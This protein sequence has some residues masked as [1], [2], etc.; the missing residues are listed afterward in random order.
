MN[1]KR[2]GKI[3]MVLQSIS[4]IPLLFFGFLIMAIAYHQCTKTI[5]AE[6]EISLHNTIHNVQQL[7]DVAYPGDYKLM[8]ETAF[9]LYKGDIITFLAGRS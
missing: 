4:I 7:F 1:T 9:Q 6:I 5:H 2:K 3:S 8:G